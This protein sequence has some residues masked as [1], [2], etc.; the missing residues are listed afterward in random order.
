MLCRLA[1]VFHQEDEDVKSRIRQKSAAMKIQRLVN[2]AR[3][4]VHS[5]MEEQKEKKLKLKLKDKEKA[6]KR[7]ESSSGRKHHGLIFDRKK[8]CVFYFRYVFLYL[9]KLTILFKCIECAAC[10][11]GFAMLLHVLSSNK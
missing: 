1:K 8:V 5:E 6:K 10:R 3:Q 4:K 9:L 11:N 2:T 7:I